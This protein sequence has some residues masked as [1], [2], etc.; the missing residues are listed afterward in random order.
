MNKELSKLIK[1]LIKAKVFIIIGLL[2]LIFLNI[3]PIIY[4]LVGKKEGYM[5]LGDYPTSVSKPLLVDDF[6][7]KKPPHISDLDSRTL[8]GYYPMLPNSYMQ[9]TNNTRYWCTPNNGKCSRAEMCNA[10]YNDKNVIV[11]PYP[12]MI[13]WGKGTRVNFYDANC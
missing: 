3:D 10:L 9:V 8:S 1:V 4:H 2:V 13:P 6:P 11:P 5:G 12:R 7:L